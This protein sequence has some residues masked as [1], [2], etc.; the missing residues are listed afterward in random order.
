MPLEQTPHESAW[1]HVTGEAVFVDDICVDSRQLVGRVC[2]S[3]HAH[4]RIRSFDLSSARAVP[5]VHAVLSSRE[6]PGANQMGP[7][8]KDEPCLAEGE[9]H[10]AGQAVFLIAG[11]TED[12]CLQ[13][14]RLIQ[15]EYEPL[16]AILSIEQA[17]AKNTLLGRQRTMG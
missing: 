5:G 2:W 8:V 16:E 17:I 7:V 3:P 9:V 12:A 10:F 13:A 15:I 6:I 11:E 14:E 4:A 1:L